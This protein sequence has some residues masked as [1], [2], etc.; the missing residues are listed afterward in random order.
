MRRLIITVAIII[1]MLLSIGLQGN[2]REKKDPDNNH[3]RIG[4]LYVL[5][6]EIYIVRGAGDKAFEYT[7]TGGNLEIKIMS[8]PGTISITPRK[9]E[10]VK[11]DP[12][13]PMVFVAGKEHQEFK[14]NTFLK[15][16]A[17]NAV[18]LLLELKN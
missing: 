16:K 14:T 1:A 3:P 13:V 7:G 10:K 17:K 8:L 2:N 18:Y 4:S 15:K 12:T 6:T 5:E 9:G 11:V